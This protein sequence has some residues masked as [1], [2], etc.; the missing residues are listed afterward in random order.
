MKIYHGRKRGL[1]IMDHWL[2]LI[3]IIGFIIVHFGSKYVK[4]SVASPRS[5]WFSLFG[6]ATIAYMFL[7]LLPELNQY[8]EAVKSNVGDSWPSILD[9]YTYLLAL[10]GLII[11]F[12]MDLYARSRKDVDE[13][14]PDST[15][16]PVLLVHMSTFVFYNVTIGYL[17]IR[18]EFISGMDLTVYFIA[19]SAHFIV[20]DFTLKEL[21]SG[22]HDKYGRWI[23]SAAVLIGWLIGALY[24]LPTWIV[25]IAISLLAGGITF[26]V[27]KEELKESTF[28]NYFAFVG[29]AFVIAALVMVF[30]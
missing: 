26:N 15:S 3:F 19:L 17:L 30:T 11:Y 10:I 23:L 12:G 28:K 22:V 2:S 14:D 29:G 1:I 18:G 16:E 7:F 9:N 27:F 24:E 8:F 6:G 21:H 25:S 4:L 13:E 5:F 20:T